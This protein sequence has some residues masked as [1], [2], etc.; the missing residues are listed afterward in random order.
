[1]TLWFRGLALAAI[2][3][4][5]LGLHL[6]RLRSLRQRNAVLEQLE[7][8]R[9]QALARAARGG[10]SVAL[11]YIDLDRFKEVNDTMPP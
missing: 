3:L 2:T 4:L 9:E 5:M 11:L 10:Y 6:V 1:M 8:Q 7:G